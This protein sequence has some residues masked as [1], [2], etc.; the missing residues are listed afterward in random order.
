MFVLGNKGEGRAVEAAI[1]THK[2]LREG[3]YQF[4][5]RDVGLL[6]QPGER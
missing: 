6:Q 3:R 1:A 4:L 2:L 5:F